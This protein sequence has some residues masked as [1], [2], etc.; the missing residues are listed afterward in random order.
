MKLSLGAVVA[1]DVRLMGGQIPLSQ[2]MLTGEYGPI[3]AG[4]ALKTPAIITPFAL[5]AFGEVKGRFTDAPPFRSAIQTTVV[6]GW[7]P[8]QL[9]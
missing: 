2:S 3:E 1:A 9:S 4:A 6:G 8:P 5:A 7:R